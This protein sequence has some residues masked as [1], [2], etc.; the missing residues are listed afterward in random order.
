MKKIIIGLIIGAVI[1]ISIFF[2]GYYFNSNKIGLRS[3]G[4]NNQVSS[5]TI[6]K[7]ETGSS[8]PKYF[9]AGTTAS[10]T[11]IIDSEYYSEL[12][13][14]VCL[15]ASTTASILNWMIEYADTDSNDNSTWFGKRDFT[16]TSNIARSWGP[17]VVHNTWKPNNS[18][19]STTCAQLFEAEDFL[20]VRTRITYNLTGDNGAVFL[21]SFLK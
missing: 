21:E 13:Q 9:T 15:T 4:N 20:G 11:H 10:S 8:T 16:E 5:I 14:N 6:K 3:D 1:S 19:A 12:A 7:S 17:S 18:V 2:G